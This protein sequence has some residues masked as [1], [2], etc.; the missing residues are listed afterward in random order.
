MGSIEK[1]F[2]C[3][4][5]AAIELKDEAPRTEFLSATLRPPPTASSD[6]SPQEHRCCSTDVSQTQTQGTQ[7]CSDRT[8]EPVSTTTGTAGHK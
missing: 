2:R 6:T 8:V 5:W 3:P 4:P 7:L 1:L